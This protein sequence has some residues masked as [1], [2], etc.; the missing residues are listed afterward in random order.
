MLEQIDPSWEGDGVKLC[1]NKPCEITRAYPSFP[2]ELPGV[3]YFVTAVGWYNGAPVQELFTDILVNNGDKSMT[4]PVGI[5]ALNEYVLF[6]IL[7]SL[8]DKVQQLIEIYP[9]V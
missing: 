2:D 7:D 3:S 9:S 6:D 1:F 8:E 4:I 5:E